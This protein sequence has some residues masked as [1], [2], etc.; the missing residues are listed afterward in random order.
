MLFAAILHLLMVPQRRHGGLVLEARDLGVE[1]RV[2][3]AQVGRF[4]QLARRAFPEVSNLLAANGPEGGRL[5]SPGELALEGVNLE[6]VLP[7]HGLLLELRRVGLLLQLADALTLGLLGRPRAASRLGR[8]GGGRKPCRAADATTAATGSRGGGSG[9]APRAG[10]R[11]IL[12]AAAE[13]RVSILFP[14]LLS[15][16]ATHRYVAC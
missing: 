9:W 14:L 13:S 3:A 11:W 16:I 5:V 8:D 7:L 6:A 12:V 2:G 15:V 1:L 4:A 10:V